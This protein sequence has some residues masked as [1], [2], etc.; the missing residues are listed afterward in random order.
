M[1]KIA[2]KSIKDTGNTL[3]RTLELNNVA[4]TSHCKS[5]FCG[6]CRTTLLKGDVDYIEEPIGFISEGEILPCVC[7]PVGDIEIDV[8]F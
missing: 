3:L 6:Q 2:G 7:K 1:I 4:P 5:G 8:R